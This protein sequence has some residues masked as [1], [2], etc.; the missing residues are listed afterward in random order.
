LNQGGPS[1][2]RRLDEN[3]LR[4][5]FMPYEERSIQRDGVTIDGV[6]Y[7]ADILR[8]WI[9]A[10]DPADPA[11]KRKFM[12]RRD[13]RDI[14]TVY[15]YDPDA[16]QYYGIPYRDTSRPAIS[17]WE[18]KALRRRL[19]EEGRKGVDE[20]VIFEAYSRMREI[21]DEAARQSKAARRNRERR[22]S[23][24]GAETPA[25]PTAPALDWGTQFGN[26]VPFDEIEE[27][28]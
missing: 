13:P 2:C 19:K 4:L 26:I 23:H 1:E 12:V 6:H 9:N 10:P 17:V 16:E 5:D 3:R 28:R 21:E 8:P 25:L 24:S 11:K 15:L 14:S 18:F 20:G 22:R 7:Y 27:M